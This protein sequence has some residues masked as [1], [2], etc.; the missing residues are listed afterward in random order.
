[1]KL[2]AFD[3]S[4]EHLSIAVS[5][6]LDGRVQV[7]THEGP[8]GAMASSTLI[9]AALALLAQA[10]PGP[11]GRRIAVLG[12]MLE[13]GPQGPAMHAAI[14]AGLSQPGC[15]LVFASGPAMAHLWAELPASI[16]GAWSETSSDIA[17]LIAAEMRP[18]DVVMVKGSF[19]SRMS[20]V[21]DA[22]KAR[23]LEAAAG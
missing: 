12:D 2:L 10:K 20:L 9:P 11:D 7:R 8:G 13:L 6:L 17:G 14:G 22:L 15:D 1:M 23:A 3:T 16:R 21:V 19:G 5:W 18:G 4:T